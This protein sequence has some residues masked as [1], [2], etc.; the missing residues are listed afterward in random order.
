MNVAK[1]FGFVAVSLSLVGC[2]SDGPSSSEVRA[3]IEAEQKKGLAMM[4][5][6]G[7]SAASAVQNMMPKF[8][9]AKVISCEKLQDRLSR[10]VI[11]I[12]VSRN[13]EQT[14]QTVT[15]NFAKGSDGKWGAAQ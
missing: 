15:S 5:Q 9:D 2:G 7:G 11:E 4:S 3:L 6:I 8:E 13:G 10:C 14:R 1:T 12:E